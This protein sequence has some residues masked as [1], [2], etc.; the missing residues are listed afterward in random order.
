MH[1]FCLWNLLLAGMT[2]SC[3]TLSCSRSL[4][5]VNISGRLVLPALTVTEDAFTC[6]PTHLTHVCTM[7]SDPVLVHSTAAEVRLD[8]THVQ[9]AQGIQDWR[10]SWFYSFV[11]IFIGVSVEGAGLGAVTSRTCSV[12]MLETFS[13]GL[14]LYHHKNFAS[15]IFRQGQIW[16]EDISFVGPSSLRVESCVILTLM[17]FLCGPGWLSRY[18]D[19]LRDGRSGDRIPV[20]VRFCT[21]ALGPT[22]PLKQWVPGLFWGGGGKAAGLG[23]NHP[24]VNKTD[25]FDISH[26]V[27]HY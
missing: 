11:Y 10:L 25:N 20:E 8:C 9:K 6:I 14:I 15:L 23:V 18:S 24:C 27:R 1:Y 26:S 7:T 17:I 21:P 3:V 16:N 19:L 12:A 22:Q 2:G 4:S 5:A 13:R